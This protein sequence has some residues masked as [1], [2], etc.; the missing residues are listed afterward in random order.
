MN[1]IA[2]LSW[3]ELKLLM[4]EPFTVLFVFLFPIVVLLVLGG[5]FSGDPGGPF[6]E[7]P[8]VDYYTP[9][10]IGTV[11]AALSLVG[12]PVHIATYRERGILRRLTA[13]SVSGQSVMVSQL[14]VGILLA[15]VGAIVLVTSA[16]L[17]Y[18]ISA[19][20]SAAGVVL[21]FLIATLSFAALGL[22]IGVLMPTARSAQGIGLG[23]FF[24][25]WMLSG[26][27]PPPDVMTDTMRTVSEFLPMTWMVNAL[28]EPWN[29][30]ETD[31]LSLAILLVL[32][33]IAIAGT[34][35]RIRSAT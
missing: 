14:I 26:T 29:A 22:L 23:L 4:R 31:Y 28:Q 24:P 30:S 9:A 3:V 27:G 8:A 2:R 18:Q 19:P 15:T 10:Y 34:L 6:A 33:V 13:S 21:A 16:V 5:V 7:V 12:I 11:I 25:M 20:A 35:L 1:A 17:V 32:L